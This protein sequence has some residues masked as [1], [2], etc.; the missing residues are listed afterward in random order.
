M[1]IMHV[2]IICILFNELYL[3]LF[4][5]VY[6]IYLLVIQTLRVSLRSIYKKTH[7]EE[8]NVSKTLEQTGLSR[9]RLRVG[10]EIVLGPIG[11]GVSHAYVT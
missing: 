5:L 8:R 6:F 4:Y 7:V 10:P 3:K 1:F 2:L 9:L 11:A